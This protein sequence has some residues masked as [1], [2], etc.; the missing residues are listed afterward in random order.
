MWVVLSHRSVAVLRITEVGLEKSQKFI[1][2]NVMSTNNNFIV[3]LTLWGTM[4]WWTGRLLS[5]IGLK[6]FYSQGVESVFGNSA[7]NYLSLMG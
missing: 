6:M 3:T 1:P 2:R 5:L 4:G 7:L